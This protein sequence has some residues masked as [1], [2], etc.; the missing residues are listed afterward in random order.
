MKRATNTDLPEVTTTVISQAVHLL[1]NQHQ[2]CGTGSDP[3]EYR[4][5]ED[6]GTSGIQQSFL[7]REPYNLVVLPGKEAVESD[8]RNSEE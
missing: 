5:S 1:R 3:N 6:V 2:S 4:K 7:T 8:K